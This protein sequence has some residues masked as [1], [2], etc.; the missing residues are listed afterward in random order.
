MDGLESV[1]TE[2]LGS[3]EAFYT[4][5]GASHSI[6]S[7]KSKGVKNC[8]YKTLRYKGHRDIVKFLIKDCQ[9]S[10]EALD[11]VFSIG[12]G[13]A[14]KDEVIVVVKVIKDNKIWQQE[15]L[16]SSDGQ[17]SAMQKATAFPISAVAS[18]M[19]EGLLE[20]DKEQR[21]DYYSQYSKVLSYEDIGSETFNLKI[22]LLGLAD[23][24]ARNDT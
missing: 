19:A 11:K 3:L 6:Y 13:P 2:K 10:D 20:G 9:L 4:S 24:R 22:N 23:K 7:M 8:S 21:R 1:T 18:M 12:C 14:D 17:F 5:G 15:K 16:I